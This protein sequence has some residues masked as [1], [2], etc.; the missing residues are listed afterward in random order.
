MEAKDLKAKAD[1]LLRQLGRNPGAPLNQALA[2]TA[3]EVA[4][5]EA[6]EQGAREARGT[7]APKVPAAARRSTD[8]DNPFAFS[9][10]APARA[11]STVPKPSA[12]PAE[13]V[14]A[15]Q[16]EEVFLDGRD[17]GFKCIHCDVSQKE[18]QGRCDHYFVQ[19]GSQEVCVACR[20]AKKT[21]KR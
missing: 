2:R 8:Y 1:A 3:I 16:W 7:P 10:Q 9:R 17:L 15:H 21:V 18:V 11:S 14:C 5:R 4:L 19:Q 6:Y 13:V 20:K 12:Q